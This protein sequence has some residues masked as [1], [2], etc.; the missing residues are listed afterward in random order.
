MAEAIRRYAAEVEAEIATGSPA[1]APSERAGLGASRLVQVD[2]DVRMT[3]E[4]RVREAEA[5][6]DE[7]AAIGRPGGAIEEPRWFGSYDAFAAW[8]R[9]RGAP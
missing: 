1:A 6:A 7:V 4:Q 2:R 3:A 9:E 8:R 5:A